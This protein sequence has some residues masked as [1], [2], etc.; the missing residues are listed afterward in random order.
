MKTRTA[1]FIVPASLCLYFF[2]PESL[3][4]TAMTEGELS[5]VTGQDGIS[6][7]SEIS[8]PTLSRLQWTADSSRLTLQ[9]MAILDPQSSNPYSGSPFS[10]AMTVDA[11]TDSAGQP[12]PFVDITATLPAFRLYSADLVHSGIGGGNG[13]MALDTAALFHYAGPLFSDTTDSGLTQISFDMSPST[14]FYRQGEAGSPE[15]GLNNLEVDFSLANANLN[16]DSSGMVLQGPRADVKLLADFTYDAQGI[17]PFAITETDRPTLTSG[18]TGGLENFLATLSGGGA[19]TGGD[20]NIN[21]RSEGVNMALRWD[22]ASDFQWVLGETAD[23]AQ[24]PRLGSTILFDRWQSLD[25]GTSAFNFPN[26]TLDPIASGQAPSGLCWLGLTNTSGCT[27]GG[28]LVDVPVDNTGGLALLVRD[29]HLGAYSSGV[30][31]RDDVNGDGQY[32]NNGIAGDPGND[33]VWSKNWGLIYTLGDVDANIYLYPGGGNAD[34]R[35]AGASQPGLRTDLVLKIQ[36]R[37]RDSGDMDNDGDTT[38]I[39]GPS[40]S[41]DDAYSQFTRGSHFMI[42]D[43]DTNLA[44]GFHSADLLF[45][46]DDLYLSVLD[47]G[48]NLDSQKARLHFMGRFG[49][50][51]FPDLSSNPVKGLDINANL[52]FSQ[53][54]LTLNGSPSCASPPCPV[55]LPFS[56]NMRFTDLDDPIAHTNSSDD[57][58]DDGSF[59]SI[60]EPGQPD[61]DLRLA[62]IAGDIAI[63]NGRLDLQSTADNS[64][65]QAARLLI[66]QELLFGATAG[67][68]PLEVGRVEFGNRNLGTMVIPSGMLRTRVGLTCQTASGTCN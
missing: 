26:I 20:E 4:L 63:R 9:D 62:Q 15:W 2:S 43:T 59:I 47:S 29:G 45:A 67:G 44:V 39:V 14:F 12:L 18:W 58:I 65:G 66:Q 16:V 22:F 48:L 54:A 68:N 27:D 46:A 31:V 23:P 17:S 11:G 7:R 49:G 1:N 52:E 30:T 33:E 3:A 5:N 56:G 25:N 10:V 24:S 21:N 35:L 36:S 51:P 55:Y 60:S 19:W 34:T 32:L 41:N 40:L 64:D 8:E 38:E 53:L 13:Q 6:I 42:A 28:T 57:T 61:V 50:G 37:A